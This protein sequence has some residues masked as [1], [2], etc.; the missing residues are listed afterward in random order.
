[1][2]KRIIFLLVVLLVLSKISYGDVIPGYFHTIVKCVKITNV[3]DYPDVSLLGFIPPGSI[4]WDSY[5]VTSSQCLTRG[6]FPV[7]FNIFAVNK[8]YLIGK[9]IKKLDLPKDPNAIQANIHID[10][11]GYHVNDSIHISSIEEYYKIVGFSE[12][13][14]IL[15]KWKEVTKFNDGTPDSTKTFAYEGEVS[16]LSQKLTVGINPLQS[17]S[18]I[19]LYPNPAHKNFHVRINNKYLGAVPVDLV[20]QGGKIVK[21][22]TISKTGLIVDYDVPVGNLAKGTYFVNLKF[23]KNVESRKIVIK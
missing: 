7:D 22:I 18:S 3:D 14:V 11:L 17:H 4:Y 21:S 13:S 1:M 19:E 2:K 12:T 6:Y 16:Q 15:H 10:P 23:G 8:S 20:S 9:D 5:V